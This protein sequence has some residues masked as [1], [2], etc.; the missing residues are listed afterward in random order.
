MKTASWFETRN[1]VWRGINPRAATTSCRCYRTSAA[2]HRRCVQR[3]GVITPH[4]AR[5]FPAAEIEAFELPQWSGRSA[6]RLP[7]RIRPRFARLV[8]GEKEFRPDMSND[9]LPSLRRL[10]PGFAGLLVAGGWLAVQI[11]RLVRTEPG[12]GAHDRRGR[13]VGE[14]AASDRQDAALQRIDGRSRLA[15]SSISASVD[16]WEVTYLHVMSSVASIVEWM[17]TT[18]LAPLLAPL[19]P[20]DRRKFLASYTAELK[21]VYPPQP[22]GSVLLR[23]RRLFRRGAGV[24]NGA[25][26]RRRGASIGSRPRLRFTVRSRGP[27]RPLSDS[28]KQGLRAS[29]PV[30]NSTS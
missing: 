12:V 24:G 19:Y 18:S 7:E 11:R 20:A 1:R 9:S 4:L 6:E 21:E 17:E 16:I 2:P 26:A 30:C 28:R 3:T 8:A 27:V 5:R 14:E 23:L 25:S 15:P 22:D 10:L 13:T 29:R